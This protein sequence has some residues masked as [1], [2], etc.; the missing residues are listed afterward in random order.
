MLKQLRDFRQ[1]SKI[2]VK[3][4]LEVIGSEYDITY[5]RKEQGK[6]AFSLRE[7]YNLSKKFNIPVEFFLNNS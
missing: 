7:A 3:A 2:P 5:F 4:F 6:C 1:K